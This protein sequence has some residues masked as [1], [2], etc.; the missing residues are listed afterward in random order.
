MPKKK[1]TSR[2]QVAIKWLDANVDETE[3]DELRFMGKDIRWAHDDP[4]LLRL[5][6]IYVIRKMTNERADHAVQLEEFKKLF[7]GGDTQKPE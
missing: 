6:L 2:T 3:F 1:A 4:Q 7:A 5:L